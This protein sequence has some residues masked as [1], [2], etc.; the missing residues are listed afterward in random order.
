MR[1]FMKKYFLTLT[2]FLLL[3]FPTISYGQEEQQTLAR[4][5][6]ALQKKEWTSAEKLFKQAMNENIYD[7]ENFFWIQVDKGCQVAPLMLEELS[8]YH[9]K[10][11][12]TEKAYIFSRERVKHMPND[13]NL[14]TKTAELAASLGYLEEAWKLYEQVLRL[15]PQNFSANIYI[16]NLLLLRGEHAREEIT[17]HY[18]LIDTPTRMQY[19]NYRNKLE[20]V[21]S[22]YHLKA[23]NHLKKVKES[24]KSVEITKSLKSIELFE[25]EIF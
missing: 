2:S 7:A 15:E 23:K 12:N 18:Q 19:A 22:N 14:L 13:V 1:L 9:L 5:S 16:G 3:I 8:K 24:F 17:R 25:K 6:E 11:S 10:N 4:L 20:Q 21:Y